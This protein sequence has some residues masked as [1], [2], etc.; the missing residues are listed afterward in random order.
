MMAETSP[1]RDADGDGGQLHIV[2]LFAVGA[3]HERCQ[4]VVAH[5]PVMSGTV[6][7]VGPQ[8]WSA[9]ASGHV[10]VCPVPSGVR[11][12]TMGSSF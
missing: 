7:D 12:L 3:M 1:C 2:A 6:G 10:E 8:T 4:S 11:N 9:M 5:C